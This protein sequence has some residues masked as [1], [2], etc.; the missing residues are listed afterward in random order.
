MEK[1]LTPGHV[2][3]YF[4][5]QFHL[6]K[7]DPGSILVSLYA[8]KAPVFMMVNPLNRDTGIAI[9]SQANGAV[10]S[11][12]PMLTE[13]LDVFASM[14]LE[15]RPSN[16]GEEDNSR[17]TELRVAFSDNSDVTSMLR[18]AINDAVISIQSDFTDPFESPQAAE[19]YSV[20]RMVVE[21]IPALQDVACLY[22]EL[23]PKYQEVLAVASQEDSIR[24][25]AQKTGRSVAF[26]SRAMIR[27]MRHFRVGRDALP[28]TYFIAQA[29]QT[30]KTE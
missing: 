6:T 2:E 30:N 4:L 19:A 28:T 1:K 21:K 9:I 12:A 26:I 8:K 10:R 29:L 25:I 27:L 24:R 11:Q 15:S 17:D 22:R 7:D 16:P 23:D 20:L 13:S 5:S 3:Q 14:S 18:V